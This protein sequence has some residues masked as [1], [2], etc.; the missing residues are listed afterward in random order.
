MLEIGE[1]SES[2]IMPTLRAGKDH[3]LSFKFLI[4]EHV[5]IQGLQRPLTGNV[6]ERLIRTA[7]NRLRRQLNK[8]VIIRANM[9]LSFFA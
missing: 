3:H 9:S 6:D 2:M 4:A 8:C 1:N 7:S 5:L